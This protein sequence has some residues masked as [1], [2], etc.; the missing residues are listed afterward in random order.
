[1][2]D[3]DIQEVIKAFGLAATRAKEVGYD[4]VQIH[5]AHGYLISQFLSSRTNKREDDWG[6]S[7]EKRAKILL[8]VYD[9][10][11][12]IV[13]DDYPILVKINGSDDPHEGFNLEEA[14]Q[15]IGGLSSR[16]IN[17]VEISGMNSSKTFRAREEGY[18]Y[19]N[20]LQIKKDNPET[21]LILV[22]GVRTL[23]KMN[24]IIASGIDF[25]SI[26]RPFIREPGLVIQF[27]KGKE[28]G[29]CISCNK[30]RESPQIVK[31]MVLLDES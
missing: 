4:A 20:A 12:S 22:G 13:G 1:M 3:Q 18:F 15:V 6:G 19:E 27:E 8:K 16:G 23:D 7:L 9:E 14:S 30:C 24:Q 5:A 28:K 11:R 25:V 2:T 29:D 31:C 17:A 10:I 21:T 26:C